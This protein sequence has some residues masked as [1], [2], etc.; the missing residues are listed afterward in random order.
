M[1]TELSSDSGGC[2]VSEDIVEVGEP[3][4]AAPASEP[5]AYEGQDDATFAVTP[6]HETVPKHDVA[7]C[8][9]AATETECVLE[10][11]PAT[12]AEADVQTDDVDSRRLL[13]AK[14][15]TETAMR[16]VEHLKIELSRTRRQ[17]ADELSYLRK[18]HHA[19]EVLLL[20]S[21]QQV[22]R[23]TELKALM[24]GLKQHIF[25]LNDTLN[26]LTKP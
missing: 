3:S 4:I 11:I 20:T 13:E 2:T 10:S 16:D 18:E 1:E 25:Q 22:V 21:Q 17:H 5:V 6:N 26:S 24:N 7:T 8:A 9:E 15:E 12:F 14:L 23:S 19:N